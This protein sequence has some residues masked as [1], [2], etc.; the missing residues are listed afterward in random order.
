[1]F[2]SRKTANSQN[3]HLISNGLG[4][5]PPSGI[6]NRKQS[7][8]ASGTNETVT[9]A[10]GHKICTTDDFLERERSSTNVNSVDNWKDNCVN[11]GNTN[12]SG[13]VPNEKK[14]SNKIVEKDNTQN[15]KTKVM[16][17]KKS[18]VNE[19]SV[20]NHVNKNSQS[21]NENLESAI[22]NNHSKEKESSQNNKVD[23]EQ[24]TKDQNEVI[25]GGT[26][27]D[28]PKT[29]RKE[30]NQTE[31]NSIETDG[32][33]SHEQRGSNQRA[34]LVD[35]LATTANQR[36]NSD[37]KQQEATKNTNVIN[38]SSVNTQENTSNS[39]NESPNDRK[40]AKE[41]SKAD[42]N[43]KS[44]SNKDISAEETIAKESYDREHESEVA[45][46]EILN[47]PPKPG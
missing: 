23:N 43:P 24:R 31:L 12:V 4:N 28:N 8:A 16:E 47:T 39:K 46:I 3:K 37:S 19:S 14:I 38:E 2:Y 25:K 11:L 34:E 13:I 7:S 26:A 22:G 40:C 29:D 30:I 35:E 44:D 18:A 32:P 15:N 42:D 1:M 5:K 6:T 33:K 9:K 10:T 17:D 20:S 41:D 27:G 36:N 45:E 21:R